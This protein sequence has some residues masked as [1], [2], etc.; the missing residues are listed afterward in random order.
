[1][2]TA[3]R[4]SAGTTRRMELRAGA[5]ADAQAIA[6]LIGSFQRELTDDPSG[7]GAEQYLA[8]VSARAEREYLSSARY[9]YLVAYAGAELAGF[10]AIRDGAH[11]FHLFVARA[12]QRQG[13]ARV[14]WERAFR[15]LCTSGRD[16][17]IT[18]NASLTAVPAYQAL[19]FVAAASIQRAHGISYLPM[20]RT[21]PPA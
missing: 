5:P 14:L 15:E 3:S 19:G 20:R 1:M 10:I 4:L 7:V 21:V 11:L 17:A 8:S 18:V 13:L 16:G 2:P 9:G 6:D 12:H